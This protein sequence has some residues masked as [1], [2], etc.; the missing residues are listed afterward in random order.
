MNIICSN[1]INGFGIQVWDESSDEQTMAQVTPETVVEVEGTVKA[2][3]EEQKNRRMRTGE[4]EV[5]VREVHVLN[6]AI[7]PLPLQ[8][9]TKSSANQEARLTY[10]YLD[11]RSFAMQR[12]L[13]V[14]AIEYCAECNANVILAEV[15]I[16]INIF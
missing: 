10:R 4:V 8:I 14:S 6:P 9:H 2:R 12:N 11:L 7:H 16:G 13:R 15:Y 1:V 5:E 3:P